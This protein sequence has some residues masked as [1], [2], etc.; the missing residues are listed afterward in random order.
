MLFFDLKQGE[1]EWAKARLGIPTASNF[2]RIMTPA[3]MQLSKQADKY[4]ADLIGEKM[5]PY[6]PERVENYSS[7][8]MEWGQQ[9]EEEARRFY[10]M[11]RNCVVSNGGFCTTDDGRLGSSP[12]GLVG[13]DGCLE[14]K[15]PE[16]GT[17]VQYLLDGGVPDEYKPQVHGHLIVT[18]R[19]WCDFLSYSIGLPPLLVRVEPDLYT[20]KLSEMLYNEFLPR[21][22][23]LMKKIA[24]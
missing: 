19:A 2:G 14:I 6:M 17:H 8:A 4:I 21:Y 13:D 3:K 23:T 24:G 1:E 16:S 22:E 9:T 20:M 5:S 7:R 15:C 12:D 18:G 10:A 11:E